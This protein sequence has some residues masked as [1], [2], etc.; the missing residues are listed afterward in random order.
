MGN[1]ASP[2]L[3]KPKPHGK[4]QQKIYL[5]F[6]IKLCCSCYLIQLNSSELRYNSS[7]KDTGCKYSNQRWME[8]IRK[9]VEN[10]FIRQGK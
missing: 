1:S 3:A 2:T 4:K 6:Q 5:R 8:L 10:K 7:T 9:L